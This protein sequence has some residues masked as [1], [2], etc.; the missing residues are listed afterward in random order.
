M[1]PIVCYFLGLWTGVWSFVLCQITFQCPFAA[2]GLPWKAITVYPCLQPF[3][4][5]LKAKAGQSDHYTPSWAA[6]VYGFIHFCTT[7]FPSSLMPQWDIGEV[8]ELK[9]P[10]VS[11]GL[12]IVMIASDIEQVA[13]FSFSG[14]YRL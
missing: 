3:Y 4:S 9:C 7:S 8:I 1:F 10:S 5:Q 14:S 11:S 13:S 2:L 12:K 6:L